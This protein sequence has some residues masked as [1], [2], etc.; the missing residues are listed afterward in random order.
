MGGGVYR[1]GGLHELVTSAIRLHVH[2]LH[3]IFKCAPSCQPVH[4]LYRQITNIF[5]YPSVEHILIIVFNKN[6]DN[7]K[8]NP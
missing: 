3:V 4:A 5:A 7:K 8:K 6:S 2:V 1:G